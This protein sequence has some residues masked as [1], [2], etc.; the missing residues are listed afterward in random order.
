M[1][2]CVYGMCGCVGPKYDV[3]VNMTEV[4]G[5]FFFCLLF[6]KEDSSD[7]D[8]IDAPDD[9]GAAAIKSQLDVRLQ[10]R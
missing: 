3:Y 1:C 4:C 8:V 5:S 10:V 2:V 9:G 7:E 6:Q